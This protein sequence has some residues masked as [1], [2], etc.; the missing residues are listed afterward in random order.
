MNTEEVAQ[1]VV[2]LVRKEA[3]HEAVNT[4]Y[5]KDVV[6]VEAQAS[7]GG[8]PEKRGIDEVRGKVDWW[9]DAMEVHSFKANG[10]FVAHDRFV[11]QYDAD[12][13]DKKSK[14]RFQLSEVGVYTVKNGKIVREEFLPF[15]GR[16]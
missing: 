12:V 10:P 16:G 4:L 11:V 5:D 9:I 6:S 14:K 13:T 2:E 8:S 15:T 1:K 3:W 7:D